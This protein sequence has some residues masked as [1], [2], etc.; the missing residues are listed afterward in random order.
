[1]CY[2]VRSPSGKMRVKARHRM[3]FLYKKTTGTCVVKC[4]AIYAFY[5]LMKQVDNICGKVR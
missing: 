1:M 4:E 5:Q 2:M 3:L